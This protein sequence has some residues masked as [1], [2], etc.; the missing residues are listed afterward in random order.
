MSTGTYSLVAG[1]FHQNSPLPKTFGQLSS[2]CPSQGVMVAHSTS[3]KREL[4]DENYLNVCN[5]T[6]DQIVTE[7]ESP[8]AYGPAVL[9]NLAS[10]MTKFWQTEARNEQKMKKLKN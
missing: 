1:L 4:D 5:K 10:A 9:E 2:Y 7:K 8:Q 3:S 6:F